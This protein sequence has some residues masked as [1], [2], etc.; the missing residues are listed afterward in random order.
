M[1]HL[2]KTMVTRGLC[3]A[4]LVLSAVGCH[5]LLSVQNPQ[6]FSNEAANDPGGTSQP[7]FAGFP[8]KVAGKAGVGAATQAMADVFAGDIANHPADWHMM[9]RLWLADLAEPQVAEQPT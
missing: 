8:I 2:K 6:A 1:S 3:A 4:A 5:D 7:V 9:Q